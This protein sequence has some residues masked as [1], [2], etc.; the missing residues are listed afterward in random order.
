MRRRPAARLLVLDPAGRVLLFRFV[1]RAGPLAGMTYWATPGGGVED[2]ESLAQAAARELAEETGLRLPVEAPA[3][4][5]RDF[6]LRL[7]DGEEVWAQERYFVVRAGGEP[8]SRDG[9][10]AEEAEVMGEHR[11]WSRAALAGTGDTVYPEDI[12]ALL[13]A[14]GEPAGGAAGP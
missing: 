3:V 10:T 8:L 7:A 11:W 5:R 4:G 9:W 12:L 1:H 13:D 14:A 6:V 2:G